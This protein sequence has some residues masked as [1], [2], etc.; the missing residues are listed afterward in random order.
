MKGN[1][2]T[3]MYVPNNNPARVITTRMLRNCYLMIE[4]ENT[5]SIAGK[6]IMIGVTGTL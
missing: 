2:K 5:G 4:N 6:K 1:P 3:I